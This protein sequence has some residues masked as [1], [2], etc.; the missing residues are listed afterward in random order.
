VTAT[1]GDVL[2]V[3]ASQIGYHSSSTSSKYGAWYG[4]NGYWCAMFV[5]WCAAQAGATDIIPRHAYTPSGAQ[6]FRDRGLWHSG[7]AGAQAGD[8]VYF[9][10]GKGRISHVG[11]VEA[12]LGDGSV[13]T[14]E[15]NTSSTDS[16]NQRSGG[17]VARKRRKAYVV[18]Y[19]RPG[20]SAGTIVVPGPIPTPEEDENVTMVYRASGDAGFIFNGWSYLQGDDGVLRP[21]SAQEWGAFVQI[22]PRAAER[23]AVWGA[24]DLLTLARRCGMYEFVGTKAEGPRGLTGRVIGRNAPESGVEPKDGSDTR[25]Y[26]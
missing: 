25:R 12:S 16:G 20:Y 13:S 17:W 10:F 6:W 24:N 8:V 26:L 9:D 21:L 23:I 18:G 19:G 15:G 3:A 1:A 5:S 22:N 2:A 11:F 14:I 4:V 7:V